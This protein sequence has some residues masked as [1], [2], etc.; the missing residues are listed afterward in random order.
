MGILIKPAEAK[1]GKYS[2]RVPFDCIPQSE[3]IE[4]IRASETSETETAKI[5]VKF[6]LHTTDKNEVP[7]IDFSD[8][9]TQGK[10]SNVIS[11]FL[12]TIS[13][14]Q[15]LSFNRGDLHANILSSKKE[16]EYRI[17][18]QDKKIQLLL[19]VP[20]NSDKRRSRNCSIRKKSDRSK[21]VNNLY[22]IDS[23]R[24]LLCATRSKIINKGKELHIAPI[25]KREEL[26][27]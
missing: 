24:L 1:G 3:S 2:T 23:T 6:N 26:E 7:A 8:S 11:S 20:I 14:N 15:T 12:V 22:H 16:I 4:S 25:E 19:F 13:C 9:S 21:A 10:F 17:L 18:S 5:G 27:E